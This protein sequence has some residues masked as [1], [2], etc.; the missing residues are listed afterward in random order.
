MATDADQLTL[1]WLTGCGNCTRLKGYLKERDVEFTAVDVLADPAAMQEMERL[2]IATMPVLRRGEQW[3][4]GFDLG[5]VDELLG[6]DAD[7]RGR[8]LAIDELAER[9]AHLL[10]LAARAASQ[11]PLE[12]QDDPTPTMV[13]AGET[14]WFMRDGRQYYPHSTS[15]GL[16][17]HI[18]GHAEKFKRFALAAD[19]VHEVGFPMTFDGEAQSFG[20]PDDATPLY[21]VVDQMELTASDIRAW[22]TTRAPSDFTRSI[23]THY[24]PQTFHQL[25]QTMTCS[26][27]QHTRQ[28]VDIVEGLGLKAPG[29]APEDL[30]GLLMPAGVWE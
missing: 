2:G 25:L 19:G 24:G 29:P 26:I 5:K 1:Y 6:L 12:R 11:I 16:V 30:E 4:S 15:K 7:P 3:V 9:A 28:V 8:V 18:A 13:K 17:H 27:A 10:G 21:R 20:E 14:I 23:D 22:C